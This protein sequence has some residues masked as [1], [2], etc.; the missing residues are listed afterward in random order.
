METY[1]FV[2][3]NGEQVAGPLSSWEEADAA[4]YRWTTYCPYAVVHLESIT[5]H[6]EAKRLL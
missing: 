2:M 1:W 5:V 3:V 6:K 4:R